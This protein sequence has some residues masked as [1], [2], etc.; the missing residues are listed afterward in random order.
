MLNNYVLIMC[1]RKNTFKSQLFAQAQ[2]FI[3]VKI[4]A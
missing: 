3:N 1:M 4:N 2:E